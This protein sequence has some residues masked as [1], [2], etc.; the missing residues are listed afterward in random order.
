MPTSFILQLLAASMIAG[1]LGTNKGGMEGV[2][3]GTLLAFCFVMTAMG[4]TNLFEKRPLSVIAVNSGYHIV[5][6][7]LMGFIIGTWN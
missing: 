2:Q 5:S 4:A 1:I 3:L 6:Y 7:G